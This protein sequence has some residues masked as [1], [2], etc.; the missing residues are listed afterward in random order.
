MTLL[1]PMLKHRTIN[2]I[3]E[4]LADLNHQVWPD[5]QDPGV[6]G[7]VMDLAQGQP[8]THR[9]NT[10]LVGVLDDVR[11]IEEFSVAEGAHGTSRRVRPHD[12]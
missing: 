3:E 1:Q 6:E 5:A 9:G 4:I 10:E 2:L 12:G 11:S 7:S 8:I